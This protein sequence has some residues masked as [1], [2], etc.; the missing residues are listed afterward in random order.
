MEKKNVRKKENKWS[1]SPHFCNF[2]F[3]KFMHQICWS[4]IDAVWMLVRII[5]SSSWK[6]WF[7]NIHVLW[8][9]DIYWIQ[10]RYSKYAHVIRIGYILVRHIIVY[11]HECVADK[12][13]VTMSSLTDLVYM[14]RV[15]F[16]QFDLSHT[17]K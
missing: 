1:L 9:R 2:F 6:I 17:H 8:R 15:T 4:S 16:A 3:V 7:M 5:T 14:T 12:E 13:Y 10:S 11:M